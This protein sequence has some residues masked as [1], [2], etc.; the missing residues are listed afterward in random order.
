MVQKGYTYILT[1]SINKVLYIGVTNNLSRRINEHCNETGCI[2][3]QKYNCHKLVY[4]EAYPDIEQ[5]IARE[6]QLKNWKREWKNQLI[7]TINPEWN[8]LTPEIVGQC[9]PELDSEPL[10]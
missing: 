3:T 8:D 7:E 10:H 1:N 4:Y 5:A 9:H 6:K 2:F